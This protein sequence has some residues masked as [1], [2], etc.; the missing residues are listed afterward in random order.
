MVLDLEDLRIRA[1][2]RRLTGDRVRLV[3]DYPAEE[4][5]RNRVLKA[6]ADLLR[7][8]PA[9]PKG[10]RGPAGGV[11]ADPGDLHRPGGVGARTGPAGSGEGV[12]CE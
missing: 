3:L 1:S 10:S 7:P 5:Y 11:R 4:C 12:R 9:R 2:L 8:A 6:L